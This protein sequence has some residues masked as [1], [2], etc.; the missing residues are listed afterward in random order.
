MINHTYSVAGTYT[1]NLTVVDDESAT[2]SYT[3]TISI[4]PDDYLYSSAFFLSQRDLPGVDYNETKTFLVDEFAMNL[5]IRISFMGAEVNG[6]SI[7]DTSLE[8]YIYNQ[9][10][11]L[12]GNLS[13]TT[14]ITQVN[15]EYDA[16]RSELSPPG[17]WEMAA[18]CT[19]G[20][21]YMDFEIEV[22]YG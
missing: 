3:K 2:D 13:G 4:R 1:V 7:E 20:S 19:K 6:S 16:P 12:A 11:L 9:Y 8:V 21:L 10:G 14:R 18:E 22:L 5:T 15:L 17:E